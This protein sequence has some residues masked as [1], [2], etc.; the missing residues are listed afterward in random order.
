[1]PEWKKESWRL[2]ANI[3]FIKNRFQRSLKLFNRMLLEVG[4]KESLTFQHKGSFRFHVVQKRAGNE[5]LNVCTSSKIIALIVVKN[6]SLAQCLG[7]KR[8]ALFF[9]RDGISHYHTQKTSGWYSTQSWVCHIKPGS[10]FS[11][12]IQI[13]FTDL[14]KNISTEFF[15][16]HSSYHNNLDFL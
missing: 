2:F 7:E 11:L 10:W 12:S 8:K 6:E 3:A 15:L 4:L 5:A 14:K 1:M 9:I 16:R 13:L